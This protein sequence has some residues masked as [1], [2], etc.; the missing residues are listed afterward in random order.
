MSIAAYDRFLER[1]AQWGFDSARLRQHLRTAFAACIAVFA[2]WALGLEHPQWAGM[3][4]WAAS[5]PLRGQLLEKSFYRTTGTIIGTAA[6]VA[7]VLVANGNLLWLVT[8]LAVW[9]GICAGLGNLQRSFASYGTMLAGYSASMVALLDS[10]NPAH[11]YEL[12][13]DRL[14]TA[15]TGVAAALIVGWLFTPVGAEIPGNDKVRRLCARLLRDIAAASQAAA[16]GQS[17]LSPKDLAE[18]LAVM[19]AI[20]EGLDPH[21]AGSQRS[22]RSVRALR[23]LI[24][25]Q[26]SAL[27]WL[28][29]STG[30]TLTAEFTPEHAQTMNKAL[31]HAAKLL[32]TQ[33]LP[34]AAIESIATARQ[35]AAGWGHA[36]EIL[37]NLGLALQAHFVAASDLPLPEHHRARQLPVVL[38]SDWV[39][40]RRAMLRAFSAIFLVGLIWVVTGW[41]GG[42]YMLLGL[43]VMITVFSSFENPVFTMRFVTMGQAMGAGVALACQWFAWPFATSQLQMV[44]MMLP[45]IFIGA[46]LFS[47]RR[48]M[49]A[50]YDCNMVI[51]LALWPHFPYQLDVGHSLSM[52]LAIVTGP[53]AGWLAYR[54]ILPVT[55]QGR[56]DG[57]RAMMVHEIQDMAAAPQHAREVRVW[58]ARLYHRLLRLIRA[59]EKVSASSAQEAA[60]CGLA[61][62]RV[63]KAVLILHTLEGDV[64]MSESTLRSV[65]S[66]LQRLQHLPNSPTKALPLLQGVAERIQLRQPENALQLQ[67][68]AQD[69][70]E[71]KK[72]FAT[73]AKIA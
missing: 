5:Q 28:R 29:D 49:L 17:V 21:A 35:A 22:R 44:L 6:G 9:M 11:V 37:T 19:A 3:T 43:S 13:W 25:T 46:L 31:E 62:L 34:L 42:A 1:A 65:R 15:L 24:N 53:L 51:L 70:A 72:F 64:L 63:G 45:F 60:D 10:G 16:R 55:A 73:T 52:A 67:L 50:G 12:G 69:I 41:H 40:A 39:G 66:A 59:S 61:A 33:P 30:K 32:E 47:H 68:A 58:R 18:R 54:F 57:L 48:T 26:I 36:E 2:A 7:L 71:H 20:E 14:F 56:L 38:H 27:L 23:R 8:G 4:V